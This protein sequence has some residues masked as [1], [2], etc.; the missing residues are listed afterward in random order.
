VEVGVVSGYDS[1]Y[2]ICYERRFSSLL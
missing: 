1:Y 2:A